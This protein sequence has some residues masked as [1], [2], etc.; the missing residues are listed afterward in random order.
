[1][2]EIKFEASNLLLYLEQSFCKGVMENKR[3]KREKRRKT[4]RERRG[5][6]RSFH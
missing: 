4:R 3:G 1:M 2:Y 5:G 6:K